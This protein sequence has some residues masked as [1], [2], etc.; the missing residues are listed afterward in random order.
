MDLLLCLEKILSDF[1]SLFNQENL[2]F[3]KRLFSVLS[4]MAVVAH[5]QVFINQ[6]V[7]KQDIGPLLSSYRVANGMR[8]GS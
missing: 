3:S 1:R 2:R 8:M 6:V 5:S 4:Q 7:H